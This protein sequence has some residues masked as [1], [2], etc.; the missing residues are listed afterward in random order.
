MA[1]YGDI[2]MISPPS[3]SISNGQDPFGQLPPLPPPL[4]STQVIQPLSVFPV[5]NLSEDSYDYVFGGPRKTPP[6]S[7]LKLT[8]PP[9]RLRS[10]AGHHRSDGIVNNGRLYRHS[11]SYA[12]KRYRNVGGGERESNTSRRCHGEDEATLRQLLLDLQKQVSVMS[13]NLSAKLDELQ[14]GDRHLETTVA[15]CE[16]RTQLQELTKSVESCQSE[17][18]EVKRDMVAIKHELDTVQQVK[19]EIEEL[20]EYVDRLEEH[21][22][23]RKLRLLEQV[24]SLNFLPCCGLTF[25]LTYSIFSAVLGMLQFGYNTGVINA[26][27]KNIENF[28]KDVYKDRYGED[29]SEEF[30]QQLYSV[31]VSIFAIGGMLG[32]F[33]GGWMANRFGRKGGLLLNN[34]LGIS[35]ACL[36]GFTKV[37][38]SYEMLFLG[39]FIIGV[40]CGLNTSL[41]PM[42]ISEIAPL[43]L[44][45]GL[46]TVN[47]LAV[48]VGL[49]LSQVLGIEQILGTNE[50]WPVLLGLAICP[51]VLQLILLPVCPESPRYLLITKQ[52]EEEARKALRRLRA[53][54]SVEED[55]EEMRAEERAQQC[56]SHISTMEL[57]CSPTLRPPLIIGIVM[58]LSQQFSGINAVF[59]YSTS[60]FNSSGLT[61][62][63]AKFATIGIG[64]IMVV[65]TLV[66]I[67]L[68]D[69][70]GRRTL[71]LY[72]LGGMFIFSIFITISFLI[73]EMIDWMSYL[74]VVS[75][76]A[77]VVFFAVGPGS[78]PWMITAELFSQGPRPSAMA[79]AVLVNW[80]ANFVV[81]IGFPSIRTALENYTFLPFSVFLAIFWIFTYKK[82]PETKNKTFEE[83]LAL[84]RHGNGRSM[85][86]CVNSLEP[87]SMNSGIEHAA[88]MVSE[89]KTQ[90]DSLFG[91]TSF[92]LTV[93]GMGPYPLSDSTN[94]LGPTSLAGSSTCHY[95][96]YGTN[97]NTPVPIRKC[98][99]SRDS[100]RRHSAHGRI[101]SSDSFPLKNASPPETASLHSNADQ[102]QQQ[103]HHQ[104]QPSSSQHHHMHCSY[105]KDI[106][107]DDPVSHHSGDHHYYQQHQ[108]QQSEYDDG[109]LR[110]HKKQPHHQSPH[111]HHSHS[112][113]SSPHQST[114]HQHYDHE[115][116]ATIDGSEVTRHHSHSQHHHHRRRRRHHHHHNGGAGGGGTIGS[117][118]G[119][120]HGHGGEQRR[121]HHES[122][123]PKRH[124]SATDVS[125]TSINTCHEPSCP[126]REVQEILIRKSCCTSSRT[127]LAQY[128][129]EDLYGTSR[130]PSSCCTS[131]DYCY[132]TDSTSLYGSRSSLSRQNSIK[133]GSVTMRSRKRVHHRQPSYTSISLR[134][135]NASQPNSQLG[136]LTSIFDRARE[137]ESGKMIVSPSKVTIEHQASGKDSGSNKELPEYACSPSPIR[138]SFLA[139]GTTR[140]SPTDYESAGAGG[141]GGGDHDRDHRSDHQQSHDRDRDRAS[142]SG[143]R[144]CRDSPLH[145]R[146]GAGTSDEYEESTTVLYHQEGEAYNN[147]C[148]NYVQCNSYLDH[149][150]QITSEDIHEYLSKGNQQGVILNNSKNYPFQP[151]NALEFQY[152]NNFNNNPAAGGAGGGGGGGGGGALESR[153]SST[154]ET[155]LNQNSTDG[156]GGSSSLESRNST[157]LSPTNINLSSSSNNINIVFNSYLE[158]NANE[159]KFINTSR[160]NV[161]SAEAHHSGYLPYTYPTYDYTNMSSNSQFDKPLGIDEI[162][163]SDEALTSTSIPGRMHKATEG[164]PS[165]SATAVVTFESFE[166]E[167]SDNNL[168]SHRS[169]LNGSFNDGHVNYQFSP[170]SPASV[171]SSVS[172]LNG[173]GQNG[174]Q[175]HRFHHHHFTSSQ[176]R[177]HH[178]T[179]NFKFTNAFKG[180]RK[181]A[182]KCADYLKKK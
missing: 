182:R 152:K 180:V 64:A 92:S 109:T 88:L 102:Q 136:S 79:I 85:L 101:C 54:S 23:R 146:G 21:T 46:G 165:I 73:K 172:A 167:A 29:I 27:E 35:G 176:H 25:F 69:R 39:R 157:P 81:G 175:R 94:L 60:L 106:V 103:L 147:C 178:V 117:G 26:P 133:S 140:K 91:T 19:E 49:L 124:R 31:A 33:S 179:E 67:P 5:S 139:D 11:F 130:R 137:I 169:S 171:A 68:M 61:E 134:G 13:M 99:Y 71:H 1:A 89:E 50:G 80:M 142:T 45:G 151:C 100:F 84:F 164:V 48:T 17:V 168:L 32:G 83:I 41:V 145:I 116:T 177:W 34:V 24:C 43:N 126:D 160:E 22:H 155:N 96:N 112:L 128:F 141:H 10:D 42:Y 20:R 113:H 56:E 121:Q 74:S 114:A 107:C 77:F 52:W 129:A 93:E 3:S 37:S 97:I 154:K 18:S 159:V 86:N 55:I 40:N 90:H 135:L 125:T 28:M 111:S 131:S 2:S 36:M 148:S 163:P 12:P 143:S 181:R 104:H 173:G 138:W 9:I 72:G 57:I 153:R 158:R 98:Y 162:N 123:C 8:S 59:Y 115:R 170:T 62:E 119:H 127:E 6:S 4:R 75:V 174:E 118:H 14:R 47:Q 76:L 150:L 15:L 82:V 16:I 149:D 122:G 144:K 66:S 44:R 70:T 156:G 120:H 105:E 30:I 108:Q 65:M 132:H 7:T 38:H 78:I 161:V 63:S 95:T 110:H 53:S 58:Q 166:T 51:A 87:Q